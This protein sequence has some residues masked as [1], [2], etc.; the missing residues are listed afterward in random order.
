MTNG[1]ACPPLIYP[2]TFL[3]FSVSRSSDDLVTRRV[4]KRLE[5][6][7]E[8]PEAVLREYADPDSERYARMIEC[9][10]ADMELTS[11]KFM[12]LDDLVR[13]IGLPKVH[14]CTH[15]WDNSSEM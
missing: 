2:C 9:L 12:R 6:T 10:R 11:L 15:C 7:D 8:I 14:L 4:I 3:N 5:G 1:R 13:A